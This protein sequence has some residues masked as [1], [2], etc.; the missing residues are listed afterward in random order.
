MDDQHGL[1]GM[2]KDCWKFSF[3]HLRITER[4]Y[5]LLVKGGWEDL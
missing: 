1:A 5:L 2:Y 3:L 4:L